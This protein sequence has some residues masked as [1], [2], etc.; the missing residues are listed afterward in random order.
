MYCESSEGVAVD[1]FRPR[2]SYPE[3]TFDWPNL[4]WACSNCNSNHKRDQFP[5]GT[6]G[7][8]L[9]IDPTAVDPSRH[10]QLSPTTGRY[11]G[12]TAEG[13]ESVKVFGLNRASLCQGRRD[14]VAAAKALVVHYD[15]QIAAGNS[16]AA[17][18]I[19]RSF[20]RGAHASLV[21]WVCEQFR[22]LCQWPG[23]GDRLGLDGHTPRRARAAARRARGGSRRPVHGGRAGHRCR[24]GGGV[25]RDA[26]AGALALVPDRVPR[27]ARGA[28][29][30]A[31]RHGLP[32]RRARGGEREPGRRCGGRRAR[33]QA[34]RAL[35]GVDGAQRVPA[36]GAKGHGAKGA[37]VL[38]AEVSYADYDKVEVATDREDKKQSAWKRVPHGP[39]S[40]GGPPRRGRAPEGRLVPGSRGLRIQG[41]LRT[42]EM[43]GLEP[44]ARVLSLFLVNDRA[45]LEQDRDLNFVFQVKLALRYEAASCGGP[46]ARA[47]T[48]TTTTT[49]A[50]SRSSSEIAASGPSATTR[51]SSAPSPR[52]T[53][54]CGPSPPPRSLATK[55]PTSS[56]AP[57]LRS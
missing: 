52:P 35:P 7:Q 3:R 6:T 21:S 26:H 17:E 36:G 32:W 28:G 41:E 48:Q 4:L 2:A 14:A 54:R 8:P 57:C 49:R 46:T 1:H 23:I 40:R 45:A 12:R 31:G 25:G 43:E 16:K 9:L 22:G 11:V 56:T 19:R 55:S 29:A 51:A 13:R 53:A 34:A 30:R 5:L 20:G 37:D 42:T 47:R 39:V 24:G 18:C 50:C 27:A 44:G 33:A 10:L 15:Q 38:V